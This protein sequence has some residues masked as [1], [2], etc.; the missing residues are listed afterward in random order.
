MLEIIDSH[1][2][3]WSPD[4]VTPPWL[5]DAPALNRTFGLEEWRAAAGEGDEFHLAAAVYVEIDAAPE[6]LAT[7]NRIVFSMTAD[8]ANPV[9][10]AVIAA[11]LSQGD[12][13]AQLAPWLSDK[14]LKGARQVLHM[15]TAAPG[16]CLEPLFIA[17]LKK[18]GRLRLAF[19]ACMR[20]D[21]LS[22]L[23]QAAEAAPE[24]TIILDHA[25][26]P[27][28]AFFAG[29]MDQPTLAL[30][31]QGL[32]Q[33]A[34]LDNVYCKISGL[35]LP[36]DAGIRKAQGALDALV[37]SFGEDRVMFASNFPVNRLGTAS[38]PWID[39]LISATARRGTAWQAKFFGENAARAYRLDD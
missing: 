28:D 30:W 32:R 23:A 1:I 9:K 16:L 29:G 27:G 35:T 22:D 19:D 11:R 14:G 34:A 12:I 37:D 3:L 13:E 33:L 4:T 26:N 36:N 20:P 21:E 2:H 38:R 15:P 25:G 5:I 39:F 8:P 6:D 18:L 10:G 7:E 31:R 17:N 24:T